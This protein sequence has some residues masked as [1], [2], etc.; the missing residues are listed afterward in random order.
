MDGAIQN[1]QFMI[2]HFLNCDPA[3][4]NYSITNQINPQY[5]LYFTIDYSHICK[6]LRNN[7]LLSSTH[8]KRLLTNNNY[9]IT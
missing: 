4:N 1:R 5:N 3:D 9:S 7:I 6:R 8:G 2:M